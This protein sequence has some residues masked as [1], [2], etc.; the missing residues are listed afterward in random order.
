[1][2]ILISADMEG[3]SGVVDPKHVDSSHPEYQRFRQIMTDDVNAAVRGAFAGGATQVVISDAH[4]SKT[5]ILVEKLDERAEIN[6]GGIAPFGMIEGVEQGFDGAM[7]VGYHACMGTPIAILCHTISGARVANIWLNDRLVGE[8]GMNAAVCGYFGTPA[9]MVTGDL[10]TCKEAEEWTPGIEQVVVKTATSRHSARCLAATAAQKLIE[11][12]A[13][14]A[15]ER[16][17]A[18][19]APKKLEIAAPARFVLELHQPAQ[20]DLASGLP[21]AV[22]LDGRRIAIPA[23]EMP[24]A[25]RALRAAINLANA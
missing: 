9:I 22:R 6:S 19:K 2:R 11:A 20:A 5:N 21:G 14:R 13:Q 7:F 25:Y 24:V 1:M 23:G 15:V 12:S 18:G 10:A 8:F 3:I 17:A 4:G 16:L